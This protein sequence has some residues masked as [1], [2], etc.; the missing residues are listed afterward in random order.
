MQ[1]PT[2]ASPFT[3]REYV[4]LV[5]KVT[6][7]A[8]REFLLSQLVILQGEIEALPK[9]QLVQLAVCDSVIAGQPGGLPMATLTWKDWVGEPVISFPRACAAPLSNRA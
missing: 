8:A 3:Y 6:E 7:E 9:G 5:P 1:E 4:Y 2:E